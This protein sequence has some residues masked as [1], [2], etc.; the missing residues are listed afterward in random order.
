MKLPEAAPMA[1][2]PPLLA[3]AARGDVS[4]PHRHHCV[5]AILASEGTIRAT[6]GNESQDVAGIVTGPDVGHAIDAR[7]RSVI[8]LFAEPE[9]VPGASLVATLGPGG[10]VVIDDATRDALVS[11]L[12]DHPRSSELESWADTAIAALT[13]GSWRRPRMHPRVHRLVHELQE[14]PPDADLSLEAL[15]RRAR[16][17]PSRFMHVFTE[18]MGIPLRPYLRWLRFQRA[19]TAI[20]AGMPLTRAAVEAGFSDAAH[21]TRTFTQT[22]GLAPSALQR[23]SRRD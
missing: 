15:A 12:S 18:S 6:V 22:F 2:W 14:L 13:G 16:L 9:S 8:L 11:D 5:H 20:V 10:S 7:D 21:M 1:V 19:A 3:V 17:S 4:A 23:R